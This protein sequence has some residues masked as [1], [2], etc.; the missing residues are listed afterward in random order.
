MEL[1]EF[2]LAAG[3]LVLAFSVILILLRHHVPLWLA[4]TAGGVIVALTCGIPVSDWPGLLWSVLVDQNFLIL[5]LMIF[6]ILLLSSVQEATGQ[7]RLLVEGLEVHLRRPRLRL[8]LFPALIGLLPMPGGALFSC[9]MIKAAAKDM[10]ISER[11]KAIINYWFRHIWELAWPLYPGYVLTCSLLGIPLSRLWQLTFPLVPLAFAVGWFFFMRDIKTLP[12]APRNDTDNAP[13]SP[14]LGAVLL[15]ALPIGVTLA[16]A[17]FFTFVFAAF[18]HDVPSQ[19]SFSLALLCAI[20]TSLRQ[21][22]HRMKKSLSSLIVTQNTRK[23]LVL[24]YAIFVFKEV[25]AAS[26]LV[27]SLG[28]MG[29]SDLAVVLSF[30]LLPLV[31]GLL[32]G[33]MVGFIG[34]TFPILLGVLA[35]SPMREYAAPLVIL[36][37]VAGNIGQLLTP[38][39]VCLVVTSEYFTTTVGGMLRTLFV[40]TLVLFA[41]GILWTLAAFFL[42]FTL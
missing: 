13:D 17:V 7:S 20:G 10:D 28:H 18:F 1:L 41:G 23:I 40:P 9:P 22:R 4:V 38:V 26:G 25:V 8:V 42:G 35:N 33:V 30:A 5:C 19:L 16:G 6:L 34:I 21:G 39:H 15:H 12:P 3:K 14:S 11:K 24:L 32:T 27:T 2:A 29:T 31:G 36:G 37:L